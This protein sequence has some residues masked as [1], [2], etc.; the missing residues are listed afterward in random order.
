MPVENL[1]L[2]GFLKFLKDKQGE[3][4]DKQFAQN[5]G[6]SAQYLCDVYNNR[7]IPGDKIT[8]ALNVSRNYV[9]QVDTP[10]PKN[11]KEK[12]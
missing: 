7:R 2:E 12:K 5:L 10:E 11:H 4:T 9:F 3:R 6:V 1:D 8:S